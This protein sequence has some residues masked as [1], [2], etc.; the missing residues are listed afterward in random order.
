[1]DR[2]TTFL[3]KLFLLSCSAFAQLANA[4]TNKIVASI[5]LMRFSSK[6]KICNVTEGAFGEGLSGS[7]HCYVHGSDPKRSTNVS[8]VITTLTAPMDPSFR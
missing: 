4:E 3:S 8:N 2:R 7:R 5:V 1:M 6:K